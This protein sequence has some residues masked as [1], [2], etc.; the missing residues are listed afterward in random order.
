MIDAFSHVAKVLRPK[1]WRKLKEAV[2]VVQTEYDKLKQRGAWDV[3]RVRE[4]RDVKKEAEAKR[5]I[6]EGICTS[7]PIQK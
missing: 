7:K 5:N 4:W 2:N 3:K 6:L 1:D